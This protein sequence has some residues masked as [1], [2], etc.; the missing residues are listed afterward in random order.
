MPA[1]GTARTSGAHAWYVGSL[2]TARAQHPHHVCLGTATPF[3]YSWTEQ[4]P[5]SHAAAN[6]TL[7]SNPQQEKE[8][9][10]DML[11]KLFERQTLWNFKQLMAETNQP[12]VW[13]KEV[14]LVR[15]SRLKSR[16]FKETFSVARAKPDCLRFATCPPVYVTTL[17]PLRGASLSAPSHARR[18][19]AGITSEVPTR[20][21]GRSSLSTSRATSRS[22]C[23]TPNA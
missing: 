2:L 12:A 1:A 4:L 8:P 15:T 10:M 11:F 18:T 9:L 3:I 22:L 13:L 19:C 21:N 6:R 5:G 16:E 17:Q 14:L 7:L 23:R 20:T